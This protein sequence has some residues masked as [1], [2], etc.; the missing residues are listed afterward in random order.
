MALTASNLRDHLNGVPDLDAVLTRLLNAA[1]SHVASMLGVDN[2]AP[3]EVVDQA[4]LMLAAHWY[5]NRE[6]S[7]VGV[8][9]QSLPL[10]FDDLIA[11]HRNYT[12]GLA[13]EVTD[14]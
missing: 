13:D 11:N 12:F 9:A 4:I 10:G 2:D 6:A 3:A 7:T 5:E 1:T 14:V 8:T